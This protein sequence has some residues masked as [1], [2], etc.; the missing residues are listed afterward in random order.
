MTLSS[1]AIRAAIL[2]SYTIFTTTMAKKISFYELVFNH[3]V[4]AISIALLKQNCIKI[5]K[6][7]KWF[8]V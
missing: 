8:A 3:I 6:S 2:M 4:V 1:K 7:L 5:I